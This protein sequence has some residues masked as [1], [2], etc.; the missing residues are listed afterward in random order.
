MT[1]RLSR[2]KIPPEIGMLWTGKNDTRREALQKLM[3]A[4]TGQLDG[5]AL[6]K[7]VW[8]CKEL[9]YDKDDVG[10]LFRAVMYS[11]N[12]DEMRLE[13]GHLF[14]LKVGRSKD[15]PCSDDGIREVLAVALLCE[16]RVVPNMPEYEEELR[17]YHLDLLEHG[18]TT[19]DEVGGTVTVK[20]TRSERTSIIDLKDPGDLDAS[21]AYGPAE[22]SIIKQRLSDEFLRRESAS[23]VLLGLEF[24]IS[25]L[26]GALAI[27]ERDE[28]TPQRVLTSHPILFGAEYL[29]VKP[30]YRLGSE[31][32]M[33]F[34]LV[35]VC[36]H[37]DLV[38]IEPPTMRLFNKK[39]NPKE[40]LVHA[41]QQ[42]LD[43]LD[44]IDRHNAYARDVTAGMIRPRGFVVIGRRSSLSPLEKVKLA[45]R[46]NAL[47]GEIE[48]MT[49][50]DILDRSK[51]LQRRLSGGLGLAPASA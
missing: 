42:V 36:G 7:I 17:R 8:S 34:A 49:Y 28:G 20:F 25:E 5:L 9:I 41:E 4:S 16:V 32:E 46:N 19:K 29:E 26:E 2:W 48:I 39:G 6:H 22:L 30:K 33:D 51:N 40:C 18:F 12:T 27:T 38:E 47:R 24:A 37:V 13:L 45:R 31:F 15:E 50:D 23:K 3:P 43:W 35:H 10:P 21:V 14:D 44:W 1:D 11:F